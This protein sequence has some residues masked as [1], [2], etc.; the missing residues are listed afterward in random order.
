MQA[1][2]VPRKPTNLTLD[3]LLLTEARAF[4]V[5]LSQAAEAGLRRAVTEAKARAW[6]R[7]N[8]EALA[9]SNAWIDA[10]G[11]PLDL[12]RQF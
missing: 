7:E 10:H 5:N 11:L 9:S 8:A 3:P 1:Q 2:S 6:Q 4:G 12:Y